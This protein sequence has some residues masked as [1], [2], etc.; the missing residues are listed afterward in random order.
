MTEIYLYSNHETF[1]IISQFII[2]ALLLLWQYVS[3]N[4][5]KNQTVGHCDYT[6]WSLCW[7]AFYIVN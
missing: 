1:I 5:E 3:E 2:V 7:G 4:N 6:C